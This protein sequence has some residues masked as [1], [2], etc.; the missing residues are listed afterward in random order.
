MVAKSTT[1]RRSVV[2]AISISVVAFVLM[3]A[4]ERAFAEGGLKL[5]AGV[6]IGLQTA[7]LATTYYAL[8]TGRGRE[9]NGAMAAIVNQPAAMIAVKAGVTG[10]TIYLAS[11]LSKRHPTG[12]KVVLWTVNAAIAGVVANN[13]AVIRR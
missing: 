1:Y 11:K 3:A 7:D 12:A 5:P 2:T 6:L 9:A 10:G 8:E 4:P 13:L